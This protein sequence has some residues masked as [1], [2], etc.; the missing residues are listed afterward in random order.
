MFLV[1]RKGLEL[2]GENPCL[3]YGYGGFNIAVTPA[4][5]ASRILWLEL[6]AFM[7]WLT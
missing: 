4:F 6:G 3:L 7:Q 2:N 1:H 5:S